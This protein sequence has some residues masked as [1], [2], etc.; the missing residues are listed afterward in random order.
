MLKPTGVPN[1]AWVKDKMSPG[2]LSHM[3]VEAAAPCL[4]VGDIKG[5]KIPVFSPDGC[6]PDSVGAI[7][8]TD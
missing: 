6:L 3:V 5:G 2:S 7:I 4:I 8:A 1:H